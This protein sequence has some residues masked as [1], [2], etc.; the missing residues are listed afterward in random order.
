MAVFERLDE[1][2]ANSRLV[3]RGELGEV[4]VVADSDAFGEG[5]PPGPAA[6]CFFV[7]GFGAALED[8]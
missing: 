4:G 6:V 3:G 8:D 5:A 1:G 7:A 2:A